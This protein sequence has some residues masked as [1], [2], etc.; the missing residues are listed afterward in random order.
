[1]TTP[2]L[3]RMAEALQHMR[4][5][6]SCAEG[7]WEDCEGGRAALAVLAEYAPS[8]AVAQCAPQGE[9]VRALVAKWRKTPFGLGADGRKAADRCADELEAALGRELAGQGREG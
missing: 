4:W 1:M 5:C 6:S 3:D 9:A 2:L 7:F 8:P